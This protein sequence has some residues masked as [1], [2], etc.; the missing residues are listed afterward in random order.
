MSVTQT[1]LGLLIFALAIGAGAFMGN[2][3]ASVSAESPPL[4]SSSAND[5]IIPFPEGEEALRE[6]AAEMMKGRTWSPEAGKLQD[7]AP[8][9]G[10]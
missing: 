2:I 8:A 6:M 9:A 1:S 7:I 10:E 3:Y 5:K 4:I